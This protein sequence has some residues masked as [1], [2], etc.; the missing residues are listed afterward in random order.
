MIPSTGDAELHLNPYFQVTTKHITGLKILILSKDYAH[1]T[2]MGFTFVLKILTAE[3][4]HN[5]DFLW[6]KMGFMMM[7]SLISALQHLTI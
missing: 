5:M 7:K 1:T 3:I 2:V 6:S 4:L